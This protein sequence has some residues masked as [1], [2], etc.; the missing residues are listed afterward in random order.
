MPEF[1]SRPDFAAA[2]LGTGRG[3]ILYDSPTS[4]CGRRV[5]LCLLEK[6]VPFEIRWLD[7]GAMEQKQDW[8]LRLNPSGIVPT[9][10]HDGRAIHESNVIN[11]YLDA[12]FASPRLMPDDAYERAQARMWMAYELD[13]AKPFRDAIYE[14]HMKKRAQ[15]S[16]MTPEAL[17]ERIGRNTRAE[18][19][20]RHALKVLMEPPNEALIAERRAILF[21]RLA[22]M[23]ARLADGRTWLVGDRFGLA[24][25]ALAPRLDMFPRIGVEDLP[26]R[27]PRIGAFLDRVRARPSWTGSAFGFPPASNPAL[28]RPAA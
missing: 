17:A 6:G 13:W 3:V 1:P 12:V 5:R 23:E 19:H 8:Y 15:A 7:L 26:R 28:V 25:I 21:D 24:D 9:L 2:P 16:G 22:L 20:L 11:E 4:P 27:F 14:T 18:Y 10:V